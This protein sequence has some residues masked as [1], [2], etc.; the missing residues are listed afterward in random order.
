MLIRVIIV[1][2]MD[3]VNVLGYMC[4]AAMAGLIAITARERDNSAAFMDNNICTKR[5]IM[6][7]TWYDETFRSIYY[8][9]LNLGLIPRSLNRH[10][11]FIP[12]PLSLTTNNLP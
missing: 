11:Y 10:F 6:P 9:I 4:P 1:H 12:V 5:F 7:K 8:P 2:L 3:Q